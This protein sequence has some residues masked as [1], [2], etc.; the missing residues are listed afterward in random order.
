MQPWNVRRIHLLLDLGTHCNHGILVRS[1][2][3]TEGMPD[4]WSPWHV[5]CGNPD[6]AGWSGT[7]NSQRIG[8]LILITTQMHSARIN[9][10]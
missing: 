5:H 10:N 6:W 9:S 4:D 3:A 1:D 7:L 2:L 8:L